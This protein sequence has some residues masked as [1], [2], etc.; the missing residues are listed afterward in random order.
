[1]PAKPDSKTEADFIA[2]AELSRGALKRLSTIL[3][4]DDLKPGD[5]SVKTAIEQVMKATVRLSHCLWDLRLINN[6]LAPVPFLHQF[7]R[8]PVLSR[9]PH[10][11]FRC[12]RR[13]PS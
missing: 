9:A 6:L 10:Q 3:G 7:H 13:L 5:P 11:S 8:S 12:N 1:M 4:F 2:Q